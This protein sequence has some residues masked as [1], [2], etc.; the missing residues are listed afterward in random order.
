[1]TNTICYDREV[2]VNE[3]F[4][5]SNINEHECYLSP[6][7]TIALRHLIKNYIFAQ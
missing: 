3:C 2:C 1:M 6:L 5:F 4:I 7:V